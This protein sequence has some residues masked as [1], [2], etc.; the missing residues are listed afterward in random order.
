MLEL[1]QPLALLLLP[2]PLLAARLLPPRRDAGA[3]LAVPERVG[4]ALLSG[5]STGA[6][7]QM[8]R[9]V[10]WVIWVLILLALA[11]P[12][13]LSPVPALKVSGRDLAIALDLSGSMVR[14][15]FFLDGAQIARLEAVQRVG[16]DFARRRAGDRVALIVF[17]SDAY[18]AAPFSFDTEAVARRIEEA[19]IGISGR[20]TNISDALGLALKRME[21]SEAASRV[22]ILLS[23]GVNNAGATAPRG[24]AALAAD[25][26]VRVHTIALG[27]K[28]L[29][30]ADEGERGVVDAATL[31]AI[32]EIS[33]G[34]SFRVRTTEDLLAVTEAL[35]R[36]EATDSDGLAA[37]VYRAFWVWPAALAALFGLGLAWR[38]AA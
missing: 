9:A 24:V 14:D 35:D 16:A 17:G 21:E 25:M 4:E 20:A 31:R 26:G 11:G 29:E 6:G 37:E 32:S 13:Q 27:P 2:L 19:T 38:E 5:G 28:D 22:V 10:P 15:D 36:L 23:D 18:Y 8:Q 34:E 7:A 3:A 33:G 1:A 30:S 12:R